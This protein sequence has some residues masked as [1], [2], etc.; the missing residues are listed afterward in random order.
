MC[1]TDVV[2]SDINF[3][4]YSRRIQLPFYILYMSASLTIGVCQL[5][6]RAQ[7]IYAMQYDKVWDIFKIYSMQ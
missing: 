7:Y 6:A 1:M 4:F 2:I 5:L 3:V